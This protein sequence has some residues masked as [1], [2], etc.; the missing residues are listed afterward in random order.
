MDN[1][2]THIANSFHH[3]CFNC[4]QYGSHIAA[5]CRLGAIPKCCYQCRATDHLVADCPL[6]RQSNQQHSRPS[7]SATPETDTVENRRSSTSATSKGKNVDN[8]LNA[9]TATKSEAT[10]NESSATDEAKSQSDSAVSSKTK[11]TT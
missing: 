4:G 10:K 1:F 7:S 6:R 2:F 8:H 3:R 9:E 11:S 5:K